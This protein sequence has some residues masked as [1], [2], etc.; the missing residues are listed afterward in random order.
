MTVKPLH[1]RVLVKRIEEENKTA[2]GIIIPDNSKEKPAQ[3]E[4]VSVGSGYTNQ[5]G[6]RRAL[7][8]KEGDKILFG[9][10][11]GSEVKVDGSDY[12]IMKEEEILGV[13]Q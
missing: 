13:L 9:K 3:G 10:Y 1:D 11:A 5:D 2:G 12:L 7:E 4:V 8:V 6:S